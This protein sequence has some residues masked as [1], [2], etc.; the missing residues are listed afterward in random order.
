MTIE[1]TDPL[2]IRAAPRMLTP[3]ALAS[4]EA[5]HEGFED[6]RA[7]LLVSRPT[8]RGRMSGSATRATMSP[9]GTPST[10]QL[11]TVHP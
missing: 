10:V 4:V 6:L 5:L 7:E 11:S 1:L 3:P 2:P 9:T 8:R